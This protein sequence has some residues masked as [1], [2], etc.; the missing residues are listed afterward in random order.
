VDLEGGDG[1][2]GGGPHVRVLGVHVVA[3]AAAAVA[4]IADLDM[5]AR[6]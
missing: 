5:S 4:G 2:A 6:L 1:R 3:A